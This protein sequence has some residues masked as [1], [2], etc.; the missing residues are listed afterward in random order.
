MNESWQ[1]FAIFVL[2]QIGK[3]NYCFNF[4]SVIF[5]Q[6]WSA[7]N[8]I[9]NIIVVVST[10]ECCCGCADLIILWFSRD[11]PPN[12][13]GGQPNT[14][15]AGLFH[16]LTKIYSPIIKS[17]E[18]S[19]YLETYLW[20]IQNKCATFSWLNARFLKM[21]KNCRYSK[22]EK[23]LAS[24]VRTE[25]FLRFATFTSASSSI[26]WKV[27]PQKTFSGCCV[28]TSSLLWMIIVFFIFITFVSL[29]GCMAIIFTRLYYKWKARYSIVAI[30]FV[31]NL[32][33]HPE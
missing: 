9:M 5:F 19:T 24:S 32:S 16:Q 31:N 28:P 33:R 15:A 23:R 13:G 17:G 22:S 25:I 8:E 6:I 30:L 12:A 27:Y 2:R 1:Y 29:C 21:W 26:F 7:K 3:C 10:K 14:P 4:S 20:N 18:V 11:I